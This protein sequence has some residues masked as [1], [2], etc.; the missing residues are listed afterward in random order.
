MRDWP[1]AVPP[2]WLAQRLGEVGIAD[3]RFDLSDPGAGR[4][5][6][7]RGHIPGAYHFDLERDLSTPTG[8][9]SGRHPLPDPEQLADAL[10]RA[11]IERGRSWV[12]AYDDSH[13]AFAARFWWLLRYLG[14]EQV[15]L[16][17]GGFSAWQAGGYPI[18][19]RIPAARSGRFD[20]QPRPELI[21]H[22]ERVRACQHQ[23]GVALI[24]SRDGARYRGE[25]EPLDPAAGHIPGAIN[26][27]WQHA[28]D[29][30]GHLRPASEHRQRWQGHTGATE[31]I[32]YCGS[33]VT[34]CA[35]LLSL[36]MAGVTDARLYPG[37][38]SEWCARSG[39][40]ATG[41]E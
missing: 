6:Y 7:E 13:L 28:T 25:R 24:D 35:N 23:A 12:V 3:C 30:Q 10:A 22:G 20:A 14:H 41:S 39:V 27:P 36:A 15:A 31:T 29:A 19:R 16:L 38:W 11:G 21:A 2:A 26:L 32:V 17:D 34:A 18:E 8:P 4:R 37:G 1:W 9:A 5:Q 40:I 33:G